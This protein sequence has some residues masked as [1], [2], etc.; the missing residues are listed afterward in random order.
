M[1]LRSGNRLGIGKTPLCAPTQ[2]SGTHPRIAQEE[3]EIEV[4]NSSS[5]KFESMN[6]LGNMY[7]YDGHHQPEKDVGTS[8]VDATPSYQMEFIIKLKY[9]YTNA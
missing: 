3:Q 9:D 2:G 6:G 4:G 7:N 1:H 5:S 8:Q